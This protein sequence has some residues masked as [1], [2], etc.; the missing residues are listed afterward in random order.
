MSARAN[1][2]EPTTFYD[3]DDGLLTPEVGIWVEKKYRLVALYDELFSTGTKNTWDQRVYVD[4]F[5]GAGK[6]RIR[7]TAKVLTGSPLLA[8]RVRDKFNHHLFCEENASLIH[9]LKTRVQHAYAGLSASY[10]EGDCNARIQDVV[11]EIPAPSHRNKVLTFCFVDPFSLNIEF[12]SIR[13]LSG[14]RYVDFLILLALSMDAG[15]NETL[16]VDENNDKI[17]RFLGTKTW[18][19][20][21]KAEQKV[22]KS[23]RM[24]L[25]ME[26]AK[27]MIQLGYR[28]ES[29]R[30]MIE[31]RSE[32]KNLPLYHLA[33]FSRHQLGYRYWKQ[34]RKYATT[35]GQLFDS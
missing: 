28:S 17:D 19:T 24:F 20:R 5:A 30:E 1:V 26:Y 16:Y 12:E 7:N 9:T 10:F 35:Q 25:A 11:R 13:A 2:S 21:W 18:R 14:A 33:F 6:V 22:G 31:V 27:Q 8:L 23:F 3:G 34:V 29:S 32:E 4:L 15:R